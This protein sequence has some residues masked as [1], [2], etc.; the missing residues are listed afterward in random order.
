VFGSAVRNVRA[1]PL[2]YTGVPDHGDYSAVNNALHQADAPGH[3]RLK[4]AQI[5]ARGVLSAA[6][7]RGA[8]L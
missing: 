2:L 1:G 4:S 8:K 5:S 7:V 6:A 3:V